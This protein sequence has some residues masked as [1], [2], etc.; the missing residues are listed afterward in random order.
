M[1][2]RR[3]EPLETRY[4]GKVDKR[5]PDECW[6]W[7][8]YRNEWCY[9]II[10]ADGKYPRAHRVGW[11]F[12]TGKPV[13]DGMCVCHTCDNP[14]CQNPA[15]LF[16]GTVAD[17]NRDM[18]NKGRTGDKRGEANGQAKLTAD[19]VHRIRELYANGGKTQAEIG[20]LFGVGDSHV[21]KIVRREK[22]SHVD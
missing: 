7:L 5:G 15:H 20:V 11:A 19:D 22:W 18:M 21:S 9:G 1:T 10:F 13:P 16:L 6:P 2:S 3:T 8:A 12:H 14:P 17:N 4:W